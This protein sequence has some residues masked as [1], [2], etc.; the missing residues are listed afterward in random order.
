MD[1]P[2]YQQGKAVNSSL[3]WHQEAIEQLLR[4]W[5][6]ALL[7]H[8]LIVESNDA[9]A[10]DRFASSLAYVLMCEAR[11]THPCGVCRACRLVIAETHADLFV[12]PPLD[13]A[14]IRVDVIRE[15]ITWSQKTAQLGRV[16]I[17]VIQR[18]ERMNRNAQNALL[19]LLEEPTDQ[20]LL[21]LGTSNPQTLLPT[22]RSRCERIVLNKPSST[23]LSDW[24]RSESKTGDE[25][26]IAL[27][28]RYAELAP[29]RALEIIQNGESERFASTEA[30]LA[31]WFSAQTEALECCQQ[32]AQHC[33]T[34]EAL[35]ILATALRDSLHHEWS[36]ATSNAS[37]ESKHQSSL[38][39]AIRQRSDWR[40]RL[41]SL[42]CIQVS[43][44]RLQHSTGLNDSIQ[45]ESIFLE[46]GAMMTAR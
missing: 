20:T 10:V 16:K 26:V 36:E 18:A 23:E 3:P 6:D 43:R 19:K 29:M 13:E 40:Q 2:R 28:L 32:V 17:A 21:I 7:S 30:A 45:L 8:A 24:L 34:D 42:N 41:E 4:R 25:S 9:A 22:V 1:S 38:S 44:N 14:T 35:S 37:L 12:I 31:A 5:Y 33:T 46:V 27:A 39:I 11:A 15:L